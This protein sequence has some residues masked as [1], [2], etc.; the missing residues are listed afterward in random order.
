MSDTMPAR[1]APDLPFIALIGECLVCNLGGAVRA[2]VVFDSDF[3]FWTHPNGV[4]HFS[5]ERRVCL[6]APLPL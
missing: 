5:G 6:G 2:R 1:A 3:A 4:R